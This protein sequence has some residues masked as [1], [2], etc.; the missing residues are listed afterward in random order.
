MSSTRALRDSAGRFVQGSRANPRGRPRSAVPEG[1]LSAELSG[2]LLGIAGRPVVVPQVN[3]IR[4]STYFEA[5]LIELAS[6]NPRRRLSSLRFIQMSL[7]AAANQQEEGSAE[8]LAALHWAIEFGT[9]EE[10]ERALSKQ[11]DALPSAAGMSDSELAR[12]LRDV[13]DWRE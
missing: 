13:R 6:G 4:R 3:G 8:D 9:D 5:C 1:R 2:L 10:F 11:L 12:A 7:R